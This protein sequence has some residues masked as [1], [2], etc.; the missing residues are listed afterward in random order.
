MHLLFENLVPN[1]ICH[2]TGTFKALDE[3]TENYELEEGEREQIG[4]Q[5]IQATKTIPSTFVGPLPDITR[6][7]RLYKAEAYSFWIQYIA[8]IVLKDKLLDKYHRHLILLCEIIMCCLLF[9]ITSAQIDELQTWINNWV[10]DYKKYYYQYDPVCLSVCPVT[11]HTLLHMLYYLR[12]TGPLWASWAFI[13]ER[14]CSYLLPAIKNCVRPYEHLDNFVQRSAQMHIVS[15][16]TH[17]VQMDAW[18]ADVI[19]QDGAP[20]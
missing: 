9:Q 3:G 14:F 8:P 18:C 16:A 12:R 1:M 4:E 10:T 19:S 6:D 5:T 15:Q 11:I 7:R 2:W 17:Q 20:A 13:M